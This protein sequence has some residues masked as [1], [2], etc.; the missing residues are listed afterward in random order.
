MNEHGT[1]GWNELMTPD[2]GTARRF[3]TELLGWTAQEVDM[4]PEGSYTVF[5]KG[6][7]TVAGM[8]RMEGPR[9]EGIPPHWLGYITVEDVDAA[10]RRAEALGGKIHHPPTDVPNVGRFCVIADP[11]GAVV[12]LISFA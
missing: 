8:M 3:F 1:F 11:T 7:K 9:W 5:R 12:A 4:G 6:E 2:A 10:A